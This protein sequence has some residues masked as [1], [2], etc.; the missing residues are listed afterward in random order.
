MP[1]PHQHNVYTYG[2]QGGHYHAPYLGGSGVPLWVLNPIIAVTKIIYCGPP[3][4]TARGATPQTA[5][6]RMLAAPMRG[7]FSLMPRP[8]VFPGPASIAVRRRTSRPA[9]GSMPT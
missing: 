8:I 6:R 7:R 3:G 2:G 4:G 5:R 1:V 9:A